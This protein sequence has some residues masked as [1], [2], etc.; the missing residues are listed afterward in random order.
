MDISS[1]F[2]EQ[3]S[4][5]ACLCKGKIPFAAEYMSGTGVPY[6]LYVWIDV[7]RATSSACIEQLEAVNHAL[8]VVV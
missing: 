1:A 7:H 8:M 3:F 2:Y 6:V 5:T 4:E